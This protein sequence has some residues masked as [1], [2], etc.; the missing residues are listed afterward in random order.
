VTAL[1]K[2]WLD[3]HLDDRILGSLTF[4]SSHSPLTS[5]PAGVCADAVVAKET[6]AQIFCQFD[7]AR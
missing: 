1:E 2:A 3:A 4:F 6:S 7:L 5:G